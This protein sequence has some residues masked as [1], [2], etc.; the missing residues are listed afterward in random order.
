MFESQRKI[1]FYNFE[2]KIFSFYRNILDETFYLLNLMLV[3]FFGRLGNL[4]MQKC[5]CFDII[6]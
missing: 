4:S 1:H 6:L 2:V 5:F 3:F